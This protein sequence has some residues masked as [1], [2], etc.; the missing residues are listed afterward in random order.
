M[1]FLRVWEKDM[2][3]NRFARHAA[4]FALAGIALAC[5][6]GAAPLSAQGVTTAGVAGRVVDADGA[7]VAGARI[8][9]RHALTGATH[10]TVSDAEGRFSLANLRPGGPW[11][12]EAARIGL[13]TVTREGLTLSAGQ[14]LRLEIELTG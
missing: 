9:F 8:E 5:A 10:A 1:L 14:R 7:P 4:S 13:Q 11:T 6:S 12:L 2:R 3:G